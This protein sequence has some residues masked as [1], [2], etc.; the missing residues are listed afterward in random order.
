MPSASITAPALYINTALPRLMSTKTSPGEYVDKPLMDELDASP[1]YQ[2]G[3]Q[4]RYPVQFGQHS[5]AIEY[6]TGMEQ[7]DFEVSDVSAIGYDDVKLFAQPAVITFKELR[8]QGTS[9][10]LVSIA[11]Q[12][13]AS[14]E[15]YA[16]RGI[17]QRI[18]GYTGSEAVNDGNFSSVHTL[19]GVD[20]SDG[21]LEAAAPG[22]QTHVI[23]QISKATYSFAKMM[24]N[25]YADVGGDAQTNLRNAFIAMSTPVRMINGT[26]NMLGKGS[27]CFWL[28]SQQGNDNLTRALTAQEQYTSRDFSEKA[29]G[30]FNNLVVSGLEVMPTFDMPNAGTSTTA[31]PISF[32]L[33]D[34]AA[35]HILARNETGSATT[36]GPGWITPTGK[37]WFTWNGAFRSYESGYNILY[38]VCSFELQLMAIR[39]STGRLN[40]SRCGII[41]DANDWGS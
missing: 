18:L 25:Q 16:K 33:V 10:E 24:S 28:A 17:Q 26:K 13:V 8:E 12:R 21:F 2:G 4:F 30:Q 15:E 6:I 7:L 14:V 29:A 11:A 22:S 27:R 34:S 23:H 36:K 3:Y 38:D 37:Q 5:R 40:L 32:Y 41:V 9:P 1:E 31:K 20:Y 35:I 39:K 19:N